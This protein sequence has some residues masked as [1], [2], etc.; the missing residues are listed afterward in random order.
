M[1]DLDHSSMSRS[2]TRSLKALQTISITEEAESYDKAMQMVREGSIY[3]FFVIPAR[4][5]K[6]AIS[7]RGPLLSTTATS[8]TSCR[9]HWHSKA[10]R[11]WP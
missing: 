2:V 9:A 6:D 7:G 11:Q 1:V 10:L 4:F 8:L 3:G 5:E